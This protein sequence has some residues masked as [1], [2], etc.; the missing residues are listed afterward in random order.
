[1][2]RFGILLVL[3]II[4][5]VGF[6]Q[7]TTIEETEVKNTVDAPAE[8]VFP[9]KVKAVIDKSCYGCHSVNGKNDHA[10][11]AL[12]WDNLGDLS[13]EDLA[14][15]MEYIVETIDSQDMPPKKLV[16]KKPEIK[17]TEKEYKILK[18]WALKEGK[19][20]SK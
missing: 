12:M 17:P 4:V 3:S 5:I 15:A 8:F 16:A 6:T 10:K 1:M 19:K 18:K 2:T 20:A 13:K 9:K 14:T 11:E 7:M